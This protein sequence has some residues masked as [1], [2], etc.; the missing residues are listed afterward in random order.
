MR[1]LILLIILQIVSFTA[2]QVNVCSRRCPRNSR[3]SSI[4]RCYC[5]RYYT[6]SNGSCIADRSAVFSGNGLAVSST[7]CGNHNCIGKARCKRFERPNF[8]DG[9]HNHENRD[10]NRNLER[11]YYA[12]DC[13]QG[14]T[15]YITG[16]Y[17]GC[18]L[19]RSVLSYEDRCRLCHPQFAVCV[20]RRYC[21]CN[22][23]Y[24]GSGETCTRIRVPARQ[25]TQN[26]RNICPRPCV[27]NAICNSQRVCVCAR[28]FTGNGYSGCVADRAA[29]YSGPQTNSIRC[30][31]TNFRCI[32]KAFCNAT[33]SYGRERENPTYDN[34]GNAVRPKEYSY[35]C[36]C[37]VGLVS[38]TI[39]EYIGCTISKSILTQEDICRMCDPV[40]GI[41]ER[42][43]SGNRCRCTGGYVGTGETCTRIRV[44]TCSPRSNPTLA[45]CIYSSR[46]YICLCNS[47]Y[48]GDGVTCYATTTTTTV[49]PTCQPSCHPTLATCIYNPFFF[50]YRCQCVVGY[51]GNG[52]TCY[53]YAA[54][55]TVAP[56]CQQRCHPTLAT[57]IYNPL[58]RQ[59]RCQCVTGYTGD[60]VTCSLPTN[61]APIVVPRCRNVCHRDADC[62]QING[63]G[64][65][66]C[67]QNFRGNGVNLCSSE[68][69]SIK[70]V[71]SHFNKKN[72]CILKHMPFKKKELFAY[73]YKK[74][75]HSVPVF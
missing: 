56:T 31:R 8:E 45:T 13:P 6:R 21:R 42:K 16:R 49:A 14:L 40:N 27:H 68:K 67:K 61:A 71:A 18:T 51:T 19:R 52:V 24:V 64:V 57:C 7:D 60:G 36:T 9:S 25:P 47:G 2:S 44:E 73:I 70:A 33:A 37:P 75:K 12:C 46:Q 50:Q 28:Y 63:Q 65:C 48:T 32:G 59:Y 38:Y 17:K 11:Y 66:R 54:R 72:I 20:Q 69:M 29:V 15:T 74:N 1:I 35:S 30:R 43:A 4:G 53:G 62:V 58:F 26:T 55:T 3:C 10:Q 5:N 34:M 22:R 41:C 39:G 23:G